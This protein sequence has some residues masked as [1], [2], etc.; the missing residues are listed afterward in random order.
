MDFRKISGILQILD[1]GIYRNEKE[2]P[3]MDDND[4]LNWKITINRQIGEM[5]KYLKI[6]KEE[7]EK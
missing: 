3:Y 2:I 7:G 4:F 1:M 5:E 6:I